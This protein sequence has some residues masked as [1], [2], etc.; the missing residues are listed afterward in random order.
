MTII[1]APV[2]ALIVF[3]V[4]VVMATGVNT[5]TIFQ[6]DDHVMIERKQPLKL[7]LQTAS[8]VSP[9][10][11]SRNGE[12]VTSSYQG[13]DQSPQ[14]VS[15]TSKSPLRSLA[16]TNLTQMTSGTSANSTRGLQRNVRGW[17]SLSTAVLP[18]TSI[19]A[20]SGSG[21]T[22]RFSFHDGTWSTRGVN[23]NTGMSSHHLTHEIRTHVSTVSAGTSDE[24]SK[25]NG[26]NTP[27]TLP[28]PYGPSLRHT[29]SNPGTT[30]TVL[31][32]PVVT[33]A[34]NGS[35]LQVDTE[36]VVKCLLTDIIVALPALDGQFVFDV[37]QQRLSD[38][39][40]ASLECHMTML[41][42]PGKVLMLQLS[43]TS[44]QAALRVFSVSET[45]ADGHLK[46]YGRMDVVATF[47]HGPTWDR[48]A[49]TNPG[50]KVWF[51][52]EKDNG[53]NELPPIVV[54]FT[55]VDVS[56]VPGL[57]TVFTTPTSGSKTHKFIATLFC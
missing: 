11:A 30:T 32:P 16:I 54:N 41:S 28:S 43:E 17:L 26:R 52:V 5:H 53:V 2:F 18:D 10:T 57:E 56:R 3:S 7:T 48:R 20:Q 29:E 40:N 38:E 33:S 42:P 14:K 25:H 15:L 24:S 34:A 49:F 22:S 39:L 47:T 50:Q 51:H 1:K 4:A 6:R 23:T 31:L 46:P 55:W 37:D 8:R 35:R 12:I 21:P 36:F 27:S 44:Q 19:V 45:A 13:A 9:H